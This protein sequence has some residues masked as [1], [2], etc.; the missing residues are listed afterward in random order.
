[1]MPSGQRR[2]AAVR[3]DSDII[4]RQPE[5]FSSPRIFTVKTRARCGD[6][7][8]NGMLGLVEFESLSQAAKEGTASASARGSR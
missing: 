8:N 3:L 2:D 5:R 6:C 1:M 4:L 7:H